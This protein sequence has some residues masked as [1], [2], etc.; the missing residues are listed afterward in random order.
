LCF[1]ADQL[2]EQLVDI[3]NRS[4]CPCSRYACLQNNEGYKIAVALM[5]KM[6]PGK[7]F[8]QWDAE[9]KTEKLAN[10]LLFNN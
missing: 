2:N 9:K 7:T 1:V 3:V 10:L 8:D 4:R 6:K 5:K